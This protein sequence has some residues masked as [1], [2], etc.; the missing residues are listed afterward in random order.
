M[1]CAAY[2]VPMKFPNG[3]ALKEISDCEMDYIDFNFCDK[4]SIKEYRQ[5]LKSRKVNFHHKYILLDMSGGFEGLYVAINKETG[6]VYPLHYYLK[7][8]NKSN[9]KLIKNGHDG[10][11][12]SVDRP[13]ICFN[14]DIYAYKESYD[15]VHVCFYLDEIDGVFYKKISYL[16]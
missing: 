14:G 12:F 10:V 15:N 3:S 6:V 7:P 16:D 13:D 11:K 2:A 9:G 1:C 8:K 5:A 4:I